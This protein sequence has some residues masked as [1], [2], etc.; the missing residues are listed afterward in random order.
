VLVPYGEPNPDAARCPGTAASPAASPGTLCVYEGQ[1]ED[2]DGTKV[3][4][5]AAE[6]L[7]GP[8]A[9][10]SADRFGAAV[11]TVA[12]ADGTITSWGTWAVTA[13]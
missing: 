12:S 4:A 8:G 11:I 13:P 5:V 7:C 6:G 1:R 10:G 2:A 9:A 3:C